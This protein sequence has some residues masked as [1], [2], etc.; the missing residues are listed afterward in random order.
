MEEERQDET[1]THVHQ[2]HDDDDH[3]YHRNDLFTPIV[4]PGRRCDRV[5]ASTNMMMM[6][7]KL[8][9]AL[10]S[11]SI[12]ALWAEMESLLTA[13]S[14]K[15]DSEDAERG[16]ALWQLY[17]HVTRSAS[18]RLCEQPR[19]VLAPMLASRLEGDYRTGKRINMRKTIPYIASSFRKDNIWLRWTKPSK[20][21]YQ[22]MIA[23]DDSES[24]R[25]NHAGRLALEA[26]VTI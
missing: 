24:M 21:A 9:R 13:D 15:S 26:L 18:Q 17:D 14:S 10:S 1:T 4:A 23:I 5:N 20:R 19:L 2:D 6:H 12:E 7:E 22:V 8:P 16:A 11:Y 3:H 25:D